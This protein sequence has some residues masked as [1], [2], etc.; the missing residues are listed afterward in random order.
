MSSEFGPV[1]AAFGIGL[2]GLLSVLNLNRK[3]VLSFRYTV[4][5]CFVC[6]AV[7]ASSI[8]LDFIGSLGRRIGLDP[9]TT[10]LS[11]GLVLIAAVCVQLSISISGLHRQ[12]QDLAE[13]E[14]LVS[15]K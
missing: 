13:H 4:G 6:L 9:G 15:H 8:W 11:I 14:A 5:W 10:V 3:Q 1:V 2:L 7:M 12:V